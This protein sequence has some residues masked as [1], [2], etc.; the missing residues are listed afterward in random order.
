MEAL[1]KEATK[2]FKYLEELVGMRNFDSNKS[3]Q[4]IYK[5]QSKK[6]KQVITQ[7]E[8]LKKEELKKE[9]LKKEQRSNESM[10]KMEIRNTEFENELRSLN[11]TANGTA[12]IPENVQ[13]EIVKKMEDVSPAFANARKIPSVHGEL[14]VAR[15][16][17]SVTGGFFGEGEE[18]LEESIAFEYATLKQKR[19][20]AALS[21]SNQL[22][23]D[24]A[25][26]IVGYVNDLVSRR[27]AK[28]VEQAIFNGDGVK[29]FAGIVND[30]AVQS[31]AAESGALT[32]DNVID[33]YTSLHPAFLDGAV[34]YM[35][36]PTF[37]ALAKLKDNNGHMYMQNGVVN[38]K[39][40]YTLLGLPVAVTEGLNATTPIVLANLAEGYSIMVKQDMK[41]QTIVDG[42][43]ALRGSQ[44]IVADGYMDGAIT[45]P[46]AIV[47]L[48]VAQS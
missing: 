37:N 40:T 33:L 8:E 16:S 17:D 32:I 23:N 7:L 36:R 4:E 5:K 28:A 34:F 6:L 42:P 24:S 43:N 27:L 18:I 31:V 13:N 25:V 10:E 30:S 15:E 20:G 11:T 14:K 9:E 26:D 3:A 46:A 35:N 41:L 21:L 1:S 2:I 38:G 45:N 19:V 39:I 44:L 29:E 47:K 22:I 12:L 48:T